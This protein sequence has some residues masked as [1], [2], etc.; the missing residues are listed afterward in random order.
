MFTGEGCPPHRLRLAQILPKGLQSSVDGAPIVISVC[1][2]IVSIGG[3]VAAANPDAVTSGAPR[4]GCAVTAP[5]V[6]PSRIKRATATAAQE[7]NF[8]RLTTLTTS[9]HA[10][11]NRSST[12]NPAEGLQ[13]SGDGV[14]IFALPGFWFVWRL[15]LP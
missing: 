14:L 11:T 4:C 3:K 5:E 10:L 9:R 1:A 2:S 8:A 12:E 7:T 15:V 6:A 13:S